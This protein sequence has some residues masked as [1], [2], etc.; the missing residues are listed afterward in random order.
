VDL[1][2]TTVTDTEAVL[3]GPGQPPIHLAGLEPGREHEH[4]GVAFRTLDRPAGER[5]STVCTV[6]DLHFGETECGSLGGFGGGPVLSSEPGERPYPD[7]MN[8]ATVAEIAAVDPDLVVAKGDL[9]T[10]GTHE[11]HRAFR[12]M[13]EPAFGERLVEVR[14]NHDA[15]FGNDFADR[16]TQRVD[17]PGITVAVLD[18]TV[19][20][21]PTGT[22]TS[23]QLEWL[24]A[25]GAEA[26]RPV[27]VFGHHHVW[28][29]GSRTR[30]ETYFGIHPDASEALVAVFARRSR[31]RGYFA[32]HTHRNRVRRFAATGDVPWVEVACVKDFPGGWAEYRVHE[33]VILQVFHRTSSP[34][35]LAWSDRTRQMYSG[36]YPAYSFGTTADRCFPIAL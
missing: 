25:V 3:H 33:D 31:L 35:A 5:L 13:Y 14:G 11:E 16:P 24:D 10:F 18:T 26:D 22:V 20:G 29:P 19:P 8:A 9:T 34:E 15:Y 36:G 6:N 2:V 4:G 7:V 30:P 1:E 12:D 28:D 17:L 27:L 21:L 23:E 32:G